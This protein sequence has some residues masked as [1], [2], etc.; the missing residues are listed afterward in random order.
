MLGRYIFASI[1]EIGEFGALD[2]EEMIAW[3]EGADSAAALVKRLQAIAENYGF[4]SFAFMDAGVPGSQDPFTVGTSGE[5]WDREYR[6]NRFFDSDPCLSRSRRT[7]LPFSWHAIDLPERRG[8][9][10]PLALKTMEAAQDHGFTDGLVIPFHFCDLLGRQYSSSSVFF[11][12]DKATAYL[13]L[14]SRHRTK[15]ELHLIMLYFSQRLMDLSPKEMGGPNRFLDDQGQ[16][17]V[18]VNLTD[19]ERDVL[20]W[21]ARGKTAEDTADILMIGHET[22]QTHLENARRKLNA[23]NKTHAVVT[24]IHLGLIDV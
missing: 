19:R 2:I 15:H 24:A 3:I 1:P 10:K 4:A 13:R 18:S 9:R 22:V 17:L 7:N 23:L 20:S 11:W 6:D 14:L 16:A 5:A 8:V 12:K 21:A